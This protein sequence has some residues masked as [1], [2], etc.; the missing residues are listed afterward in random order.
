MKRGA[1]LGAG[2]TAACISFVSGCTSPGPVASV[3]EAFERCN[4]SDGRD[5][6][7]E[8][9][10]LISDDGDLLIPHT[11]EEGICILEAANA[12]G[13]F[14]TVL[15]KREAMDSPH[16]IQWGSGWHAEY[17][18]PLGSDQGSLTIGHR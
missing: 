9:R 17:H 4:M 6:G 7:A 13:A 15:E 3:S 10:I 5:L 2:L 16:V 12:P 14:V 1:A 11:F 8:A 18:Y